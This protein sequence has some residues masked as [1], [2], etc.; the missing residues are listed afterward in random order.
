MKRIFI[1][2]VSLSSCGSGSSS[3]HISMDE[4]QPNS[5]DILVDIRTPEEFSEG[6]LENAVNVN[7]F[8]EDFV[9]NFE[10]EFDKNDTIY[11]HCKSGG[12]STKAV[13]ILEDKGYKNLIH[14]DGGILRWLEAG[15]PV[16]K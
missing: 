6:H 8:D 10:K 9:S 15:K 12:R 2:A 11:I 14:L 13:Q 4:Y 16:E 3:K 7:F 5:S 1:L